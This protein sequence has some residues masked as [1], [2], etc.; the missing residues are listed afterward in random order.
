MPWIILPHNYT[1]G[2]TDKHTVTAWIIVAKSF[3]IYSKEI[4][5]RNDATT[6]TWADYHDEIIAL[7]S[8]AKARR[9]S[10]RKRLKSQTAI[11]PSSLR[12][13]SSARPHRTY[14]IALYRKRRSNIDKEIA[15]RFIQCFL[16]ASTVYQETD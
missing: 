1:A 10:R 7:S 4:T 12:Q 13:L 9:P 14:L 6:A 5:R 11:T 15:R 8:P 3:K 2:G 16:S